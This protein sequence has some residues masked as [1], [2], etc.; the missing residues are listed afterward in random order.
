MPKKRRKLDVFC[1]NQNCKCYNKKGLKNIVRNGRRANGTQ[2]YLCRECNVAFV[3]TKGTMFYNKQLN[4]NEVIEI[5]KHIVETMSFRG[6]G[7]VTK[8]SKDTINSYVQ[9]IAMHCEKVNDFLIKDI[10]LGTHEIDEFW[11]YVKKN[12]KTLSSRTLV[13][14]NKAMRTVTLT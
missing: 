12:K 13:T 14:M 2:N 8:H 1:Q 10:K 5:C 4:K 9:L 7:R 6:I 3:R 11:S